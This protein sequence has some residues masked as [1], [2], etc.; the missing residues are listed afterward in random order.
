[1]EEEIMNIGV[2]YYP[3]QWDKKLWKSDISLMKKTGVKIA[4]LAEF[5]WCRLE[6]TE[7]NYDFQWLDEAIELFAEN[8][9]KIVLGTPTN[10]PPLWLYEKYP[11]AIQVSKN[12]SRSFIGVRG[13]RC[14]NS[15]SLRRFAGN[16]I[17]KITMHYTDNK[18]VIGWQIDNEL[19]ANHCCCEYCTEKFRQWLKSKYRTLENMNKK[20][21]NVVWSGEYSSWDQVTAPL[22]GSPYLNPSYLLDFNRYASD[23]MVEYI[24]FQAEIIRKNCPGQFITT[25]TW[26]TYNLPDFYDAFNELDFVSYDNY[27]T[28]RVVEDKE[29]LHTHAFHCDLMRGI[30]R[31]NF[32]IMEQLSGTPGCWM[33]MMR[34]PK[35]GM[36]KGYSFQAIARG[37]DNVI[38]FRWRNASIGA[39][40]FWHGLIDHSN[41]PGRRFYEFEEL[42]KDVNKISDEL[43][44]SVIKNEVA[45]LYSSE[46]EYGFKVQPQV[47]GMYYLEQLQLFHKALLSLGVGADIINWSENLSGYKVVIAPTLFISNETVTRNLYSF[48][49]A[50]G[51]LILTNRTGVK[52][53]NNNCV[54]EELPG[55]FKE[56]AGIVVEEYDP[57]GASR[58]IV[59]GSNNKIYECR[60][61]CDIIKPTTA[62]TIS[63]Y[64]DDF[65]QG[66]AAV[67]VNTYGAG[68]VY[69]LGTV[70][71]SDYYY[72]LMTQIVKESNIEYY[73][74]LPYGVELSIR[75]NSNGE[76]L[77]VF[78]NSNEPKVFESKTNCESILNSGV[79]GRKFNL[80][81]YEA[82]VLKLDVI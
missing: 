10:T 41:V 63:T 59:K 22:G 82:E 28:T 65:F 64:A 31:Q 43:K 44:D 14:Y 52:D 7:G 2:D 67:T 5:A 27:P 17:E 9:I 12:G 20:H 3:E 77:F 60:Q 70:F 29:E 54:M 25:N 69:Y 51:T 26:F 61:W 53:V 47:E 39:E 81:P 18:T 24:K 66:K 75:S 56:C 71:N 15:P 34:T 11:D 74:S 50:G 62:K 21:G 76:Y 19:E 80:K 1:M 78:N 55:A 73:D 23:S 8:D 48:V 16:I 32:W 4:R 37:A 45:I 40:M 49:E 35:P 6:P 57:I 33:P 30:K 38:H 72:D 42:C 46:Q 68:K 13:H 36:I 79:K 58:H